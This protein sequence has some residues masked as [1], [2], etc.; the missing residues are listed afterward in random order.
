MLCA[1]HNN[2]VL[3]DALE[4]DDEELGDTLETALKLNK[5]YQEVLGYHLEQIQALLIEN[6]ERQVGVA[7]D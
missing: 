2:R 6:E 4:S 7:Q 3:V 5:A 1:F